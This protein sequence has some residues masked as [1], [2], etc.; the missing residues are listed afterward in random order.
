VLTNPAANTT[1]HL[2]VQTFITMLKYSDSNDIYHFT[3]A[4][5]VG[6]P[7]TAHGLFPRGGAELIQYFYVTCNQELAEALKNETEAAAA[8]PS[9]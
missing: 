8:D 3:G 5:T 4:Q 6:Y 9:K 1:K 2:K 7:G